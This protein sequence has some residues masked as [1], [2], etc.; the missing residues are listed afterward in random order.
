MHIQKNQLGAAPLTLGRDPNFPNTMSNNY[1][2]ARK[3][4][5]VFDPNN[6]LAPEIGFIV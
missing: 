6:V 4:K 3:M 5:E 1:R 2:V